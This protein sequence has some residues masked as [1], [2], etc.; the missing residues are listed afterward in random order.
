MGQRKFLKPRQESN[1]WPPEHQVG[2]HLLSYQNSWRASSF[3]LLVEAYKTIQVVAHH[4]KVQE[5]C[6]WLGLSIP[7]VLA[8]SETEEQ[9]WIS[10]AL[11]GEKL[12]NKSVA[13]EISKPPFFGSWSPVGIK[14]YRVCSIHVSFKCFE[15]RPYLVCHVTTIENVLKLGLSGSFS[16][17]NNTFCQKHGIIYNL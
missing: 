7:A 10:S 15:L 5:V 11:R 6:L 2:T 14:V 17:Y 13:K 1:P 8:F 16:K 3:S 9:R 12:N 4:H